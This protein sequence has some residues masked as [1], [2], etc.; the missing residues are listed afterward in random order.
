MNS[1]C[2][3]KTNPTK[4][5]TPTDGLIVRKMPFEFSDDIAAHWNKEKIEWSHMVNGASLAMPYLEPYLI[6]TMKKALNSI[7]AEP[8]K[9]QI[10]LY[11]GQE[12]QHYQQH[13]RFNNT[14]IEN[15][16]R[17][18]QDVESQMKK[19]F[20]L[21]ET[22]RSDQF[23]LAYAAGFES[24]ALGVGHWL[25]NDREF[26]FA[27]SDTRVA[28]L[29][30]WHFVEEIEHKNVAIDTYNAVY[31]DYFYR[32]YGVLFA[33]LHVMKH[34][35]KAYQLMLKKDG[36]WTNLH[37]R[38]RLAKMIFRFFRNVAPHVVDS[39]RRNHHPSKIANPQWYDDWIN[40]HRQDEQHVAV[41]N[42]D[43]LRSGAL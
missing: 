18:L 2:S 39:C 34:S 26:L 22:T 10:K 16:Y 43:K 1:T 20:D 14:L 32:V 27:N 33:T 8:L 31:G 15:G 4:P 28:S 30:L 38:W 29:V 7:S 23:N 41:L 11:I 3:G 40:K 36:L 9:Q 35:R 5:H 25:I 12:A 13:R 6:R 17:A 42:T 21:F 37:S 19:E 24:M